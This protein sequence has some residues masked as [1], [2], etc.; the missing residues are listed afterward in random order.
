[1][2]APRGLIESDDR[3]ILFLTPIRIEGN[4]EIVKPHSQITHLQTTHVQTKADRTRVRILDSAAHEFALHGYEGT[5]LRRVADGAGL[6][7]GSLYF[8]FSAK[9]DLLNAV[10]RNAVDVALERIDTALAELPEAA[11][12]RDRL[13][14]AVRAHLEALHEKR[15][16][17]VAVVR[18][19]S[20]GLSES[21]PEARRQARRYSAA[22]SGLIDHAQ[23]DGCVDPALDGSAF[24]D[25][26]RGDECHHRHR[27]AHR[28]RHR[29]VLCDDP[30]LVPRPTAV[31]NK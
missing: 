11:T 4:P 2:S 30:G 14:A 12:A 9:D 29:R 27:H 22:W 18:A 26:H 5:S 13:A 3:P 24:R 10:L 23:K 28:R 15:S 17:G 21:T 19:L 31:T 8:H 7:L 1:M 6:Q 20:P 16:R 25:L